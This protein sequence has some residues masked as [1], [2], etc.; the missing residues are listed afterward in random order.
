MSKHYLYGG[1]NAVVWSECNGSPFIAAFCV[2]GAN[3][4]MKRGTRI[5]DL[6]ERLIDQREIPTDAFA[7]ELAIAK[8]YSEQVLNM[9][10]ACSVEVA[11]VV[12]ELV[13]GTLDG[14]A[15]RDGE[16]F[17]WDLKTGFKPV[18]ATFNKQLLAYLWFY[19]QD[20]DLPDIIH[21]GIWHET[22]GDFD[23]WDVTREEIAEAFEKFE[24]ATSAFPKSLTPGPHCSSCRAIGRCSLGGLVPPEASLIKTDQEIADQF[25]NIKIYNNTISKIECEA[26]ALAKNNQLPGYTMRPGKRKPLK[27]YGIPPREVGGLSIYKEE[28]MTPTQVAKALGKDGE[29]FIVGQALASRPESDMEI[30]KL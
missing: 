25:S 21:L 14:V 19:A 5:H 4:A 9:F 2:N 12:S 26:E 18:Y 20:H 8:A 27:W 28:P 15:I 23:W 7:D 6:A 24:T 22:V 13:G 1:S 16:L 11:C 10:G 29:E 30:Y 17:I 3:D